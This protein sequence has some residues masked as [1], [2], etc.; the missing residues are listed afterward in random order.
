MLTDPAG[1][2]R[3]TV[4]ARVALGPALPAASTMRTSSECAASG[5]PLITY[6]VLQGSQPVPSRLHWYDSPALAPVNVKVA[7]VACTTPLGPDAMSGAAAGATVST[8]QV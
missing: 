1:A 2:V 7:D 6:G 5:S 4:Q 3:S 8:F